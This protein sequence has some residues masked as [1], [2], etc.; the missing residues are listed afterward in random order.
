[1]NDEGKIFFWSRKKKFFILEGLTEI[2]FSKNFAHF[3]SRSKFKFL[4]NQYILHI[5]I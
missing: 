4:N 1:M 3:L 5:F 2:F